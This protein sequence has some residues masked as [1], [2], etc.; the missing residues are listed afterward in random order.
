M[1]TH[2][3][4]NATPRQRRLL[5]ALARR[6]PVSRAAAGR[7]ASGSGAA[8]FIDSTCSRFGLALELN[9]PQQGYA[10]EERQ[11]RQL[12]RCMNRESLERFYAALPDDWMGRYPGFLRGDPSS[13]ARLLGDMPANTRPGFC[14]LT[15]ERIAFFRCREARPAMLRELLKTV[16]AATPARLARAAGGRDAVEEMLRFAAERGACSCGAAGAPRPGRKSLGR[17]EGR[18][19]MS[20]REFF[21]AVTPRRCHRHIPGLLAGS[22][23]A[24]NALWQTIG[25][26]G[27]PVHR[28]LPGR[29][30]SG[31]FAWPAVG[32]LP[33]RY[34]PLVPGSRG[35]GRP[36]GYAS[37]R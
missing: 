2:E 4:L 9:D 20:D 17:I 33:G 21:Q 36:D 18:S 27:R 35:T 7:I 12:A 34:G 19:R 8:D 15:Y 10:L 32:S 16:N 37:G 30:G 5:L 31:R 23:W 29:G 13:V 25:R 3:I 26:G 11:R 24:A 14:V 6:S 22:T 1:N 28:G